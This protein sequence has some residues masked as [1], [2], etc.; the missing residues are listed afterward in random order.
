MGQKFQDSTAT[1]QATWNS[2]TAQN[3]ALQT[4]GWG[5]STAIVTIQVTGTV[6][7]GVLGFQGWDGSNWYNLEYVELDNGSFGSTYTLGN[8]SPALAIDITAFSKFQAILSTAITGTGNIF[9]T[10]N[11]SAAS[12]SSIVKATTAL[13]Y[14]SSSVTVYQNAGTSGGWTPSSQTALTNTVVAIKTSAGQIGGLDVY[15]PN[16][17]AVYLQ[18]FNLTTANVTLGTTTPTF[19]KGLPGTAAANINWGAGI[20]FN[21]AISWAATTTPTGNTAPGSA[22]TGFALYA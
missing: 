10:I 1:W 13:N 22:L 9:V 17:S 19:V 21:T 4:Y 5:Y 11:Q 7:P 18:F 20:A 3:T 12:I 8:T 15:N 2:S 16:A 14:T 6:T